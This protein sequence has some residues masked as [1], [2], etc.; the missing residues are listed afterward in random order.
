MAVLQYQMTSAS[1]PFFGS[2]VKRMNLH[3][4][5]EGLDGWRLITVQTYWRLWR[6]GREYH[7]FWAQDSER[8]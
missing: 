3:M 6:G 8:S 2:R 7:F 5:I 1:I 4:E